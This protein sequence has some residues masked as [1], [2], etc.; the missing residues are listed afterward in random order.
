[1][2]KR[3]EFFE[4]QFRK[5]VASSDPALNPFEAAVLPYLTGWV[6]DFGHDLGNLSVAMARQGCSVLALDAAPIAS[7]LNCKTG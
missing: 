1:M 3:V 5:Q 4:T 6:L 2:S 7:Y